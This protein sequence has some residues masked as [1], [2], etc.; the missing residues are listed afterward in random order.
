MFTVNLSQVHATHW[1][2]LLR[3]QQSLTELPNLLRVEYISC[4]LSC[5]LAVLLCCC[6]FYIGRCAELNRGQ[7]LNP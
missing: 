6:C 4:L 5:L 3:Q 2:Q 7:Y 1:H